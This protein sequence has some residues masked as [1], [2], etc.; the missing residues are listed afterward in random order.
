MQLISLTT[1]CP[2]PSVEGLR[3]LQL[4][5]RTAR[6][7][8]VHGAPIELAILRDVQPVEGL[9]AAAEILGRYALETHLA[10]TILLVNTSSQGCMPNNPT[11]L[12]CVFQPNL[13]PVVGRAATKG[14]GLPHE[15]WL[16]EL[17][18]IENVKPAR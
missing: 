9:L 3:P 5:G 12:A 1:C 6:P 13:P 16:K 4:F 18:H 17:F 15:G 11:R 14:V 7:D 10:Y 8:R 2:P